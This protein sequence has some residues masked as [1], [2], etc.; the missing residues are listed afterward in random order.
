MQTLHESGQIEE[1]G[2]GQ[3]CDSVSETNQDDTIEKVEELMQM[4]FFKN[5]TIQS[6]KTHNG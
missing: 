5:K 4:W 3:L 2:D 6:Q 1:E